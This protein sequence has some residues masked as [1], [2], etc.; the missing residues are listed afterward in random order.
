MAFA[1]GVLMIAIILSVSLSLNK[2]TK[3]KYL[4]WGITTILIIAPLLSWLVG[5]LVGISVGDGFAGLGVM[6]Y[7][8]IIIFIVGIV[9]IF[10]GIFKNGKTK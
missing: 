5:I 1:I 3:K 10:L 4:I 7:G 6:V 2:S 9:L 8:F